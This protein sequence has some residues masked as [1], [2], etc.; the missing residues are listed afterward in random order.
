VGYDMRWLVISP[1]REH[2]GEQLRERFTLAR[3]YSASPEEL[4]SLYSDIQRADAG[5]FRLSVKNMVLCRTLCQLTDMAYDS[6]PDPTLT[7]MTYDPALDEPTP[8]ELFLRSGVKPRPGI[9]L[10]KLCSPSGWIITPLECLGALNLWR[11]WCH[12]RSLPLDH[13]LVDNNRRPV[14]WWPA[15]LEF[16]AS[17]SVHGGLQ[18]F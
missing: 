10:H 15:W 5:Y 14:S 1:E 13:I 7:Q 18:V 11:R 2:R 16:L 12:A 17:S 3:A 8:N 9:A 6:A 4:D